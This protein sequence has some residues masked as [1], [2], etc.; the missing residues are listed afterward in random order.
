[1]KLSL[2]AKAIARSI[3]DE[4]VVLDFGSDMYYGLNAAGAWIWERLAQGAPVAM[5]TLLAELVSEFEVDRQT[6]E[7]DLDEFVSSLR[8]RNLVDVHD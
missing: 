1:L 6:A 3:D 5:E 4:A 7:R 2:S 8:S